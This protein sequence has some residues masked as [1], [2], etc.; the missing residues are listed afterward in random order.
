MSFTQFITQLGA[1]GA[2]GESFWIAKYAGSRNNEYI[3][4]I[5]VDSSGNIYCTG[6]SATNPYNNA[7][8]LKVDPDG[9]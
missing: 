4:G 2:G 9:S 7:T 8:Y 1:A 5:D 3:N 6:Q